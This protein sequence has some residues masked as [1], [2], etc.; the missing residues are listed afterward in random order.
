MIREPDLAAEVA[1]CQAIHSWKASAEVTAEVTDLVAA[2]GADTATHDRTI[3]APSDARL[4]LGAVNGIVAP[5]AGWKTRFGNDMIL[6]I[7]A[8]RAGGLSKS[9]I[10]SAIDDT[11]G[12]A[13]APAVVNTPYVSSNG[14]IV[15]SVCSCTQGQWTGSPTGYTYQW[16]RDGT[17]NLG[18]AAT[19]TLVSADVGGHAIT[20]VVTA[21]N[22]TGSQAAP[23]SNPIVT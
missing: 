17:T 19:Y 15:G 20:C 13:H 1:L 7:N 3:D 6:L 16:K 8:G 5:A 14:V 23:P 18:T 2:L 9:Q 10:I 12:I 21:T 11:F 22:A 4:A